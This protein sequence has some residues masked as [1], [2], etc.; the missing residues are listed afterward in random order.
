[1]GVADHQL[2]GDHDRFQFRCPARDPTVRRFP[3]PL[4]RHPDAGDGSLHDVDSLS[5][6]YRITATE[7]LVR[8]AF[9]R[10]RIPLVQIVEVFPTHN[11]LS[12]PALS[13][14]R[15]RNQL[16]ATGWQ[17]VVGHDLSPGQ[18][19]FPGRSCGGC[20]ART[21]AKSVGASC[22]TANGVLPLKSTATG[23]GR[24]VRDKVNV[25]GIRPDMGGLTRSTKLLS[26]FALRYACP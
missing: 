21:G 24:R 2:W 3:H 6:C 11:P 15:L 1:M 7:L 26:V 16:P 5:T 4:D 13:L 17:A 23:N 25:A 12:S 10:W 14:D 22:L 18:G 20:R 8:S 19:S 9:F